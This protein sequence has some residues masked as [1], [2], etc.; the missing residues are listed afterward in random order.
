MPTDTELV[1]HQFEF[2]HFNEKAR[3]ALDFKGIEHRRESYLPG[4]HMPAIKKMSGSTQTPVLQT[5]NSIIPGSAAIIEYLETSHPTPPLY[6]AA[7]EAKTEA[8][9]L[10]AQFDAGLGPASRTVVFSKLVEEGSYLCAM[11]ARKAAAPKRWLYRATY[12]LAKGMIAKGNGTTDPANVTRSFE[13]VDRTLDEI[14]AKVQP[15]GYLVGN[16]FSIADLTAAA[17]LAPLA[18]PQHPDMARPKPVPAS[19]AALISKY[20]GH[21]TIAW[22]GRMYT[23]HR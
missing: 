14:A 7:A 21:P 11:F 12:P 20:A 6:P 13:L 10:Q 18:N 19:V 2:S 8:L 3:W 23:Q 22:V 1:L 17:L 16:E 4:P 5:H 15:S 9:A